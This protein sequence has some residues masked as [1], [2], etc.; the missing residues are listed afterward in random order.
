MLN[1]ATEYF[2]LLTPCILAFITFQLQSIDNRFLDVKNEIKALS[3][4]LE[5]QTLDLSQRV[6]RL[7]AWVDTKKG[8]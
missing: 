4:R 2:R 5:T 1:K 3:L 7:E 6:S 8:I